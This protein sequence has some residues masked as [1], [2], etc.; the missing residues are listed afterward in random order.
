[1]IDRTMDVTSRYTLDF[2]VSVGRC[3]VINDIR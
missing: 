2:E 3:D 1:M